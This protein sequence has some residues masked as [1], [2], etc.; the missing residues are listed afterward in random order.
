MKSLQR[1]GTSFAHD[2]HD[3]PGDSFEARLR[4]ARVKRLFEAE[5]NPDRQAQHIDM[6]RSEAE[7]RAIVT[8]G[9]SANP[10]RGS[11]MIREDNPHPA[12]RPSPDWARGPDAAAFNARWRNEKR[13]AQLAQARTARDG[14]IKNRRE[15][16]QIEAAVP[17]AN[18][19]DLH[20]AELELFKLER[21]FEAVKAETRGHIQTRKRIER[22]R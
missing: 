15:L 12:P 22:D 20:Q 1:T 17:S 10:K 19:S 16:N 13:Q 21:R 3:L 18:P 14:L 2:R 7:R 9:Q 8:A 5:S 6:Q 4:E 11:K